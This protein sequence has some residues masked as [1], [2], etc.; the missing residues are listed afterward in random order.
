MAS[1]DFRQAPR[2]IMLVPIDKIDVPADRLRSL[3]E[4]QAKAIGQAI[5]ADRQ[6][7]P[8]TVRLQVGTDRYWLVDGLHRFE[9]CKLAG[10]TEIEAR[11]GPASAEAARRQEVLS[12]WVRADHD[13]FDI[14]AQIAAVAEL[15][16]F[17]SVE[18]ATAGD[19]K[20][21]DREACAM[22]AQGLR[23][24]IATAE[25]L[26]IGRRSVFRH[27]RILK[28]F[29]QDAVLLLRR[30]GLAD[31]LVPLEALS[32]LPPLDLIRV[33]AYLDIGKASTIAEAIALLT[34]AAVP[35]LFG[36]KS[37]AFLNFLRRDATAS[38]RA[39]L[40]R[41][42]QDEYLPDGRPRAADKQKAGAE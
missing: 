42:L 21:A 26:G 22:M 5:A 4:P 30:L 38:Q 31:K 16:G 20:A 28:A 18:G 35:S 3:K 15:S 2:A 27:L 17:K 6:Y 11:M 37:T 40:M 36:R 25:T 14:A 8:I 7:D 12:A 33:L 24:D 19:E 41:Q 29:D 13:I 34:D 10:L 23:W 32:G 39:E 9:G 1:G